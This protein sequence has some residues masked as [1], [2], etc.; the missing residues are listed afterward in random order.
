ML[1]MLLKSGINGSVVTHLKHFKQI[2]YKNMSHRFTLPLEENEFGEFTITLTDEL[3][4]ELGWG[5]GD[6]LDYDIIDDQLT[7]KKYDE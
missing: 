1:K 3:V 4:Q 6:Q 2:A 7:F 5:I